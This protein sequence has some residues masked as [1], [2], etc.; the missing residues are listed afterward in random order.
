MI[1]IVLQARLVLGEVLL[2]QVNDLCRRSSFAFDL[3]HGHVGLL[4]QPLGIVYTASGKGDANTG[5]KLHFDPGQRERNGQRVN[6]TM[7][8][9]LG[10]RLLIEFLAQD[11]ELVSGQTGQCVARS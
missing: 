10:L 2:T 5:R 3:I 6:D 4:Q 8:N 11:N 7:G 1:H 9:N